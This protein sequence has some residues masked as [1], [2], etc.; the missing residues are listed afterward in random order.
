MSARLG[1]SRTTLF[2]AALIALASATPDALIFAVQ[3]TTN[4]KVVGLPLFGTID[5]T[6]NWGDGS[7]PQ[8]ATTAVTHNYVSPGIYVITIDRGVSPTGPWLT[9]FG[10][11]P[12]P[13]A[14]DSLDPVAQPYYN[15]T[16]FGNLGITSLSNLFHNF[17]SDIPLP[18]AVPS[19]LTDLSCTFYR[20]GMNPADLATWDV[21]RVTSLTRTFSESPFNQ[22][23][24]GWNTSS[25]TAMDY[26]FNWAT[27]FN[28]PLNAWNT[29]NVETMRSMFFQATS[30]NQPLSSWNTAKVTTIENIFRNA[31]A[32]N[33]A[34]NTWD[35]SN[36]VNFDQAF[37]SATVF[38]QPLNLWDTSS[39]TTMFSMF[40]LGAFNQNIN[41]WDVSKVET[42]NSMF[43]QNSA[44][45][46]P[47]D[48]WDTSSVTSMYLMFSST[49]F[50]QPIGNWDTSKVRDFGNMFENTVFNQ[51]IGSWNTSGAADM[52]YMFYT[53]QFNQP[54]S[55]WD[56]SNVEY[57]NNMF[58]SNVVYNQPMPYWNVSTAV[59]STRLRLMF[60]GA[61]SFNQD[62]STWCVTN[63][64]SLP[65][66]FATGSPLQPEFY[67]VWGT[68]PER[69]P[70]EPP[71]APPPVVPPAPKAESGLS[72]GGIAAIVIGSLVFSI[73]LALL[74]WWLLAEYFNSAQ[75]S[76]YTEMDQSKP[77]EGEEPAG[78]ELSQVNS[79]RSRRYA[80]NRI[81]SA[82]PRFGN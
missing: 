70:V 40:S 73:L 56:V 76:K 32:F 10:Y 66:D 43:L 75:N 11:D 15:V 1:L 23:I 45:N 6:V 57:I 34:I 55:N 25:V 12:A 20:S 53:A 30:F 78:V 27:S 18:A 37:S 19:T 35:V 68:C 13:Q 49:P 62:I 50:N 41:T 26:T 52:S 82:R 3:T 33:G 58:D 5:V 72:G 36:V 17:G 28:Q 51:P 79:S 69:P 22:N 29:G 2:F 48:S 59:P 16:T 21:S 7:G 74:G 77:E 47:L 64:P 71:V 4:N 63:T 14:C 81:K 44:F 67:P 54:I 42:M 46:Q 24:G 65:A 8:A 60:F 38:N 31:N 80:G 9:G 39:A 61:S